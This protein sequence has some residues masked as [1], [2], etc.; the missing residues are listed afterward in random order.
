MV[1]NQNIPQLNNTIAETTVPIQGNFTH[2]QTAINLEHNFNASNPSLTYHKK[3]SMS[4]LGGSPSLPAGTNGMYYVSGGNAMFLDNSGEQCKLSEGTTGT[5]G[6]QW[7]GKVLIQWGFVSKTSTGSG[8]TSF[9]TAFPTAC[10][11]VSGTPTYGGTVPS[12]RAIVSIQRIT[13]GG[14]ATPTTSQF[15]W[16]F[17]RGSSAQYTGFYWMAIGN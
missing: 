12:A 5:G 14:S 2:L 8:T 17:D 13:S 15:K 6:F 16:Y 11:N 10:F 9:S 3:A 1:Y 4:N 7:I